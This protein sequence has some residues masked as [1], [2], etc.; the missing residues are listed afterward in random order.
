MRSGRKGRRVRAIITVE[1]AVVMGV[2]LMSLALLLRMTLY[3]HDKAVLSGLVMETAQAAKERDR[4]LI[5]ESAAGYFN[6]RV[7]GKLLYFAPPS[8][9]VSLGGDR[10]TVS[11]QASGGRMR[12]RAQASAPLTDPEKEIRL[13]QGGKDGKND[14]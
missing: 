13:R 3:L 14:Q 9:S 1:A 11:A 10:V 12:L 4:A 2:I 5:E 6:T 7:Q 8:C